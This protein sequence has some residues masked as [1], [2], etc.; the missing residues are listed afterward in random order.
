MAY[1][2]FQVFYSIF[3]GTKTFFFSYHIPVFFFSFVNISKKKKRRA[4]HIKYNSVLC[5]DRIIRSIN[6]RSTD[7][8]EEEGIKKKYRYKNHVWYNKIYSTAVAFPNSLYTIILQRRDKNR[9]LRTRRRRR[10]RRRQSPRET[11]LIQYE[12]IRFGRRDFILRR[13]IIR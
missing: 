3:K 1:A 9:R 12:I 7:G 6:L 13:P 5:R 10:R 11:V 8:K 4:E 2:I